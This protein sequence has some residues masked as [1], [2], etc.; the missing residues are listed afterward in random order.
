MNTKKTFIVTT[1]ESVQSLLKSNDLFKDPQIDII[2]NELRPTTQGGEQTL[3][4]YSQNTCN[5]DLKFALKLFFERKNLLELMLNNINRIRN[6]TSGKISNYIQSAAWQEK[7]VWTFTNVPA[8]AVSSASS[9]IC[10]I[11][12][13]L[14]LLGHSVPVPGARFKRFREPG[15]SGSG[16]QIQ[17][18]PE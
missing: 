6:D 14:S 5:V 15:S 10:L 1:E 16:S 2:S 13:P 18:V 7:Y 8:A 9:T 3:N 17:T 11:S 4:R 12:L